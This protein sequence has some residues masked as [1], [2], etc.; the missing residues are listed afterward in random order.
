[1]INVNNKEVITKLSRKSLKANRIR[2]I[3]AICAIA[4][5][6]ILFT[7]LFTLGIGTVEGVQ[8]A[9]MR[10]A[11][12][13]GHAVLK[14]ITNE[15][16]NTVKENPLIKEISYNRMLCDGVENEELAKR[17]SE[18]WYMDEAGL[19]MGFC[20]PTNG[21]VPM[22][23]NELIT[24]TKTLEL[25]GVEQ[26]VGAPIELLLDIR[27][28]KVKR[29]FTLAGWWESDPVFNVGM[30]VASRAYVDAHSEELVNTYKEDYSL[31]GTINAYLMFRDSA[32]IQER[33]YIVMAQSGYSWDEKDEN[34]IESNVNWSYLS[35]SFGMDFGTLVVVISGLILVSLTGYLIIY[36]IFQI[37]V[38]RD[39]RFYG[40]LKTIGT[41][42]QQL[43]TMIRRQ[44]L[45]LSFIGI[46]IGLILGFLLGKCLV[47]LIVNRSSYSGS[48]VVI[49]PNPVIFIGAAVFALLTVIVS[50]NRP[51]KLAG[52]VSPIEAVHYHE[53]SGRVK[54][55]LKKTTSGMRM[56]RMALSNLGRSKKRTTLV[57]LSLSLSL[58]LF[59]TVYTLSQSID[60]DKFLS[61]F[62]DTDFLIA[63]NDYFHNEFFGIG[64]ETS[65]SIIHAVEGQ[66]G[67][68]EG[69]RL[70]GG[71]DTGFAVEDSTPVE[72]LNY[73]EKGHFYAAVFGLEELPLKRLQL[74]DGELNYEKL[75]TGEYIL[76]GIQLDDYDQPDLSTKNFEVGEK[77]VLHNYIGKAIR[78]EDKEYTKREFTVMGHVAVKTYSNSDRFY[79]QYT[80]YLPADVYLSMVEKPIVM[81]YA[82]NAEDNEAASIEK[83]LK[84]YT[85]YQEMDMNYS[86]KYTWME[87]F[88][89]LRDM[90]LLIG[91]ALSLIIGLIGIMNFMNTVL[92]S[93]I[94]RRKEFAMLRSI[95]M[96]HRQLCN[97]LCFEGVYYATFTGIFSLGLGTLFSLLIV[98]NLSKM[99]W[100]LSYH[101]LIW[102]LLIT[103][104]VLLLL[105]V[106]IPRVSLSTTDRISIVEKL[107]EIE[108]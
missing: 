32:N 59:N 48:H 56:Y 64:H 47:P 77:V 26:K 99:L 92:T 67:F 69:G 57:I 33:L 46:P 90:V 86:S 70:Y 31:A 75:L 65:D 15:I 45:Y 73:N 71:R 87:E 29:R 13:G 7:T 27:G 68:L 81:S 14:Y 2:N 10:Q 85:E 84:D 30:L 66:K 43:R 93:I 41:T 34:Y 37:S 72:H 1:M 97:M 63:N 25:L 12:G 5:T 98:R 83:F 38:I 78:F 76:E 58:V 8:Q 50:T 62:V 107:R 54:T 11:G 39:I 104:P 22:K 61:K 19:R 89:G 101:F 60:M 108:G 91:G 88:Y 55:R 95:G 82:F 40:L 44:A 21:H 28:E 17:H 49:S 79:N 9:A 103:L 96:T 51:V 52:S 94:T 42:G 100:L 16:F 105:S 4:M 36:N 23:E 24:D 102:P 18:L 3:F 106:L 6:A 20:E 53:V 80:Y 74:I 35:A